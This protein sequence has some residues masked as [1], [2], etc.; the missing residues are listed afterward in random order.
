[1]TTPPDRPLLEAWPALRRVVPWVSLGVFPTPIEPLGVDGGW[2]KRD[3]LSSP[4]YGGNKVRTLEVLFGR[5]R[6]KGASRVYATG[7]FGTNHGTAT[8]LHAPRAGLEAGVL[9]FPQPPSACALENFEVL[10][11]NLRPLPHW[12]TLPAGIAALRAQHR[13]RGEI[14][15]VMV[16]GGATP[17]GALGYVSAAFEIAHQIRAGVTPPLRTIYLAVGSTCTTAG[18]LLGTELAK[19]RGLLRRAP[20]IVAVRVTPWPVTDPWRIAHLAHKTSQYLHALTGDPRTLVGWRALRA[21]LRVDGAQLG[22]GYG[23]PTAEGRAAIERLPGVTLDTTYSAKAAA[24]LLGD[25]DAG[26][27]EAP[28]LFWATKSSAPLPPSIPSERRGWA[29]WW[30]RRWARRARSS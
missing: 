21:R 23:H 27:L 1:M 11:P 20:R 25:L 28:A 18:L 14:I 22:R 10:E 2:V 26:S 24:S 13:R 30:A 3:D 6:A 7:A 19:R 4:V 5:A 15:D 29:K 8:L 16:P 12:S 9:L 17:R